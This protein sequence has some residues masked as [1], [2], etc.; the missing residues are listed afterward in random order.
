VRGGETGLLV[1]PESPEEIAH[2]LIALLRDPERAAAM[3]ASG[4]RWV[5]QEWTWD[6]QSARLRTLLLDRLR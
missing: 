3:G 5:H 6:A 4:A 2:A 1:D